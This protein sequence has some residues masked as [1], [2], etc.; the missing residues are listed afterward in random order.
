MAR[1]YMMEREADERWQYVEHRC[2]ALSEL[3][4]HEPYVVTFEEER[5][6]HQAR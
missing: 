3:D 2:F 5:G 4:Q 6:H 1:S